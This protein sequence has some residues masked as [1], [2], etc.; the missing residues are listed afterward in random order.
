MT[1]AAHLVLNIVRLRLVVTLSCGGGGGVHGTH[2]LVAVVGVRGY[3]GV[4]GV[5]GVVRE[6]IRGNECLSSPA[7][8]ACCTCGKETFCSKNS[9]SRIES[10]QTSCVNIDQASFQAK[11]RCPNVRLNAC[12]GCYRTFDL[13]LQLF[14]GVVS[15]EFGHFASHYVK[16]V[17]SISQGLS[18]QFNWRAKLAAQVV[19]WKLL[20]KIKI[21]KAGLLSSCGSRRLRGG[22]GGA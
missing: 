8:S 9:P 16:W 18:E 14:F 22:G 1:V 3:W 10:A 21:M 13:W 5:G 6:P 4:W 7:R 15:Q 2:R 20:I 12:Q 11:G 17:R 19:L